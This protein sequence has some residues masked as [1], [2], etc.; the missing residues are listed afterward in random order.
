VD[1]RKDSR[2]RIDDREWVV[3]PRTSRVGASN[4]TVYF[5]ILRLF[6]VAVI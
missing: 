2:V 6:L 3:V 1:Y 5:I 4:A